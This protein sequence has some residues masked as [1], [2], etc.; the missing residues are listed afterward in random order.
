MVA[1]EERGPRRIARSIGAARRGAATWT[2]AL[3]G[4][5]TACAQPEWADGRVHAPTCALE[6]R[7][8]GVLAS[9]GTPRRD[10]CASSTMDL[11]LS[12][13]SATCGPVRI[14]RDGEPL[15]TLFPPRPAERAAVHGW[16][17]PRHA[18]PPA[19][20]GGDRAILPLGAGAHTIGLTSS[21]RLHVRDRPPGFDVLEAPGALRLTSYEACTSVSLTVSCE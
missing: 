9:P 8:E 3:G 14:Y 18:T 6:A 16:T 1:T 5:L 2:V 20:G 10:A 21:C 15:V 17:R 4:I 7:E 19:E 13:C 11:T 12:G